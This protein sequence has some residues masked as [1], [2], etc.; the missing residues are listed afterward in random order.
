MRHQ[1][2]Q[3]ADRLRELDLTR[4]AAT[5][6]YQLDPTDCTRWK[7]TGSVLSING[8]KFFDHRHGTGGGGAI[9]LMMHGKGCNFHTALEHLERMVATTGAPP[10]D[11]NQDHGGTTTGIKDG[12]GMVRLPGSVYRNWDRV[13]DYLVR[14]RGLDPDLLAW[15][16]DRHM[17]WADGRANAVCV[18]RDAKGEPAGAELHG[19][20]PDHPFRGLARGSKKA[21]GGFWL[22]RRGEGPALLTES[23]IDTLSV[24]TLPELAPIRHV[25]S[26]AGTT[27]RL[28]QWIKELGVAAIWCGFDADAAGDH[29]AARLMECDPRIQRLRPTGG[30][31]W[32]E[33]LQHLRNTNGR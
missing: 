16:H 19:T 9:D 2:T 32:N 29:A 5:C 26:T 24:F 8:R 3:G 7:R 13:R 17:V 23:A 22:A 30:K 21:L 18:T 31:D 4:V 28:P 27:P 12:A 11:S 25:I 10:S 6:G 15:C 1:R 20:C 33:K 14:D